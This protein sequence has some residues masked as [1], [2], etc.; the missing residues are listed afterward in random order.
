MAGR[1]QKLK[2]G[3][4]LRADGRYMYRKTREGKT[5]TVYARTLSDL[6]EKEKQLQADLDD[7]IDGSLGKTTLSDWF[8]KVMTVHRIKDSTKGCYKK[9][10]KL[11][12]EPTLGNTRIDSIRKIDIEHLYNDLMEKGISRGTILTAHIVL[13]VLMREAFNNSAIRVNPVLRI[14]LRYEAKE[15][16]PLTR[17]QIDKLLRF[18]KGSRKFG[19]YYNYLVFAIET[20]LRHGEIAGL[21]WENVF[22][23]DREIFICQQLQ[24]LKL[25]DNGYGLSVSTPKT[26]SSVRRINISDNV[27]KILTQI[28]MEQMR[29]GISSIIEV[30]GRKDFVFLTAENTPLT[31]SRTNQILLSIEKAYNRSETKQAE[32]EC[33]DAELIPHLSTHVLRHTC[34][35]LSAERGL[36]I[37]ALQAQLGHK[38]SDTTRATYIH[39]HRDAEWI[40]EEFDRVGSI[41]AV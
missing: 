27:A 39:A 5:Y 1:P 21:T 19:K 24:Y 13:G 17:K 30:D 41:I 15:K 25:K 3:E 37:Y 20:G 22:I 14:H 18:C 4:S 8:E 33:R 10:F 31:V 12:I 6:R 2:H 40:R 16:T 29:N 7:G 38:N 9:A 26:K 34:A 36:D 32:K 28:R 11:Y 35:T 23:A